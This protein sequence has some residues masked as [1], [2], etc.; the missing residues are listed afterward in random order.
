MDRR[1]TERDAA[2]HATSAAPHR[3]PPKSTPPPDPVPEKSRQRCAERNAD[4]TFRWGPGFRRAVAS[5]EMCDREELGGFGGGRCRSVGSGLDAADRVDHQI[6][7]REEQSQLTGGVAT[8]PEIDGAGFA[9]LGA[10]LG[11]LV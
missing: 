8:G 6:V 5:A 9:G 11:D 10:D 4:A 3:L 1:A 7:S 2:N